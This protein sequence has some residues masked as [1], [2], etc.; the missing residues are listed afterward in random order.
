MGS[1]Y[2]DE[3]VLSFAGLDIGDKQFLRKFQ[4]VNSTV[5]NLTTD[6]K[7]LSLDCQQ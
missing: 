1:L 3:H 6:T 5:L 2:I 4:E 7:I